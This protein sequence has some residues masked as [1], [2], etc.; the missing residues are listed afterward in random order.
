M[1]A[2]VARATAGIY[3]EKLNEKAALLAHHCEQAG[4]AWQAALWHKRAAE[5]A[6]V[7]NATEGVRHWQ[8]VRRLLRPLPRTPEA[9]Q[10]GITACVGNLNLCWRL[11]TPLAEATDIFEEGRLLAEEAGDVRAQ[12]ALHGTY[13]AALGLVGGDSDDYVRFTRE[14]VRLADETGDQGLQIAA[15]SYLAFASV[16]RHK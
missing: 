3:A 11:G 6:G 10:L 9:L 2:A 12:A 4:E 8:H 13:G 7:T 1:H 15:R 5:W 16:V 14:A